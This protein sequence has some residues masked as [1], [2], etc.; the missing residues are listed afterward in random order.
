MFVDVLELAVCVN[1]IPSVCVCDNFICLIKRPKS[2]F[3]IEI[4]KLLW[5]NK[6]TFF[7]SIDKQKWIFVET[8]LGS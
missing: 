3:E 5:I 2:G 7:M 8:Y 1:E 6:S 4:C